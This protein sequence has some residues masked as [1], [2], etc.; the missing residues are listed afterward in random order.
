MRFFYFLLFLTLKLTTRLYFRRRATHNS[1]KEYLGRTIYVSNHAASF[2]DPLLVACLRNPIVFFM[3]RSDVFKPLLKPVLWASHMLPIYRQQ[4]GE[5]TKAQNEKVFR[6]SSKILKR[7][8]NILIFG[9][10]FTDDVFIRRLK[11]VKKGAARMGFT[12]L[13]ALKWKKKVYI[14]AVGCNY[15]EPNYMR[16]DILISTSDK[17]CL[18]DFKDVYDENPNKAIAEV[19]KLIEVK[20]R[21]QITHVDDAK[22]APF[23]E[24][25]MKL[26]RKGMNA[27]CYDKKYSLKERWRYSQEL[28]DWLNKKDLEKEEKLQNLKSNLES[29]FSLLK[30]I[31][32]EES[33][34]HDF[35]TSKGNRAKELVQL[36]FLFPFMLLGLIHFYL[37]YKFV[38]RFTEKTFKRK[39]FWGSVKMLMGKAIMGILNIPFIFLFYH[40][41]Y[42]SYWLG[43]FYYALI[44]PLFGLSAYLFFRIL[45][46]YK[47]KGA[48][49]KMKLE[50][51]IAK[52]TELIA[53]I[54]REVKV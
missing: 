42:P 2:M 10:G 32:L 17:I 22:L 30:K 28:A 44:I 52:R 40:F 14:A 8:R 11:P 29:Y 31:K 50:K 54:E 20:M 27:K 6:A 36:I 46:Q 41:V 51:I 39:V 7:G 45:K 18:N 49:N 24:N 34:I 5:D 4:D 13:D 12:T 43:F 21:E 25:I 38:K 23:H 26:T 47:V 48:M 35:I 3:T 9:E 53:E 1:P 33:N 16:S 37:P 19:T 15:T